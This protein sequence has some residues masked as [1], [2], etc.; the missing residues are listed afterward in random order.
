M[1]RKEVS[2]HQIGEQSTL[3][4]NRRDANAAITEPKKS[5]VITSIERS[6]VFFMVNLFP[7]YLVDSSFDKHAVVVLARR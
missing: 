4:R 5:I 7:R 6:D 3:L 1:V 2:F